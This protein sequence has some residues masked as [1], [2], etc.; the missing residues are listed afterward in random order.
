M[1]SPP[2][3]QPYGMPVL[4]PYYPLGPPQQYP[5]HPSAMQA[6][7]TQY[8][9][10][11]GY[12]PTQPGSFKPQTTAQMPSLGNYNP[13]PAGY[14][15][16][17][18]SGKP[19]APAY[20]SNSPPKQDGRSW[21]RMPDKDINFEAFKKEAVPAIK[22][23]QLRKV[24][25]M[26]RGWYTR[27]FI[28]PFKRMVHS[29]GYR[30]QQS[31]ITEYLTDRLIPEIILEVIDT[32]QSVKDYGLYSS[33]WRLM[34]TIADELQE[35]LIKTE[36]EAVVKEINR[37]LVNEYMRTRT[38][39]KFSEGLHD[40]LVR[41]MY[42][43]VETLVDRSMEPFVKESVR[44]VIDDYLADANATR[45]LRDEFVPIILAELVD[46]GCW[47]IALEDFLFQAFESAIDFHIGSVITESVEVE[48]LR[49]EREAL[50]LAFDTFITRCILRSAL[51]EARR[52]DD[53]MRVDSQIPDH[54]RVEGKELDEFAMDTSQPYLVVSDSRHEGTTKKISPFINR[55]FTKSV[56]DQEF[57]QLAGQRTPHKKPTGVATPA[58]YIKVHPKKEESHTSF[59]DF[60]LDESD[61]PNDFK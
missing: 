24:Q 46:E 51:E 53:D 21:R 16:Q 33:D 18:Y 9:A 32:S 2:P 25:A 37:S 58:S 42:S 54:S 60:L 5:P 61:I 11:P 35:Q 41:V 30:V 38:E 6:P 26:I 57:G 52:V 10:Q 47:E 7:S 19:G 40:P 22:I 39:Q 36:C 34:F 17:H 43:Y 20:E 50:S 8:A 15:H 44:E 45:L 48:K 14:P 4:M 13:E 49:L 1:S 27:K 23:A 55:E 12:L 28:A 31:L 59:P 56:I 3:H 29:V